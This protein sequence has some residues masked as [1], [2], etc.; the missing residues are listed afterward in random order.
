[1]N[2]T[3]SQPIN[4]LIEPKQKG[5]FGRTA[6]LVHVVRNTQLDVACID[7]RVAGE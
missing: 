6:A 7:L 5:G 1:M 2:T 4:T 3:Q